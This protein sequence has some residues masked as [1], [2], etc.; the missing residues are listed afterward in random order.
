MAFDPTERVAIGTTALRPTRLGFGTAEIGGLYRA[1]ADEDAVALVGHAWDA[2]VRY[3]DTAPLYGYGN[4]ERRLGLALR[5]RPRDDF[6]LSSKV[7]RLL[8]PIDEIPPD[9]DIDPQRMNGVDDASYAGTPPVRVVF[10][11][12]R[13]GVLRSVEASLARLG[14][15]R[16]DI[17]Y[18]HDPDD[19]WQAAIEG[20][21]PALHGLR[22]QG[23]VGAIG[24]GM[25]QAEMLARFA[26]EGDFD[27]FLVAG[28]Y[29]LLD[30]AALPELLPLCVEKGIAVAAGGA[31]NSGLLADPKP[32]AR[33]N[34]A[35]ASAELVA[36]AQRI[37]AV[38]ERHGVPIKAAAIQ[39]ALA[40]PAVVSLVA[41]VRTVEHF[42]DYPR[43]LATPI[44]DDLWREL[45]TEGL[46]HPDA[47]VPAAG[48]AGP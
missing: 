41:G 27:V 38:C 32:G 15:D 37:R 11:Y 33:F 20:A 31:M 8:V 24:A 35:P 7:G 26:R 40:H 19:H 28:R 16:I 2:G 47:P 17:L 14:L 10:D 21:Y 13:D 42:D 46:I 12:S 34:Y 36:R 44:P 45:R 48:P 4:A 23:V 39:F 25:N 43:Y 29:S 5:D 30:Q 3:F 1:V 22:E 6:V 9:A 18:I